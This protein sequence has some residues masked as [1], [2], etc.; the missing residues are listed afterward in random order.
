MCLCFLTRAVLRPW[1]FG[2]D[3]V[4][5]LI[6]PPLEADYAPGGVGL[7]QGRWWGWDRVPAG[8]GTGKRDWRGGWCATS[9]NL[10]EMWKCSASRRAQR[11]DSGTCK[12]YPVNHLR[13]SDGGA[14]I[15]DQTPCVRHRRP[16]FRARRNGLAL[17]REGCH[18]LPIAADQLWNSFHNYSIATHGP[19]RPTECTVSVGSSR[20]RSQGGL[21][22]RSNGC[23]GD[24]ELGGSRPIGSAG[25]LPAGAFR[26]RCTA[27]VVGASLTRK[28]LYRGGILGDSL[29]SRVHLPLSVERLGKNGAKSASPQ[30][31]HLSP[32]LLLES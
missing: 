22:H 17:H 28:N 13:S 7:R 18:G 5:L 30:S 21:V 6:V 27:A 14:T 9:L 1:P 16:A 2:R 10:P 4:V 23:R 31:E 20:R 19:G 32:R 25:A 8:T 24:A 26:W 15:P 29:G 12:L 3:L 11:R